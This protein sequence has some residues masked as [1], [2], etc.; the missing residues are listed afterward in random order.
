MKKLLMVIFLLLSFPL[1]SQTRMI[2]YKTNGTADSVLLSDIGSIAFST[3]TGPV[4]SQGLV[5]YY[6]FDGN[7]VDSSGNGYNGKIYNATLAQNRFGV[8]NNAY[9]FDGLGD[10][11]DFGN[12]LNEVFCAPVAK[13]SVSGWALVR[14]NGSS[15][16][17]DLVAKSAGGNGP[18]QWSLG[19]SYGK[20]VAE[21]FSDTLAKNYIGGFV[22]GVPWSM[23]P[24]CPGI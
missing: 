21:V 17:S 13:F 18:Y 4:P 11:I 20:I 6:P 10:A 8:N 7:A 1:L 23:V 2:I 16:N 12:I 5:A 15:V 3:A 19:Y 24:F 14:T 22:P 9:N